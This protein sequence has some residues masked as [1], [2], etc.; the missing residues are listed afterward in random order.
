MDQP[1]IIVTGASRGLGAA[2]ARVSAR[3]GARVVLSARSADALKEEVAQITAAGGQAL[4]VPGDVSQ[5]ADCH[6]II[7]QA[8]E[9]FG[10]I[11][12]LVNN[13]GI[14]EPIAPL[15]E[16]DPQEWQRSW[17]VNVLGPVMLTRMALPQ[18]RLQQGRVINIS[19]GVATNVV[20]G[21]GAYSTAKAALN[22]FTAILAGEEPELTALA[23][24]PGLVDTA[25]Q[26]IIRQKGKGRMT[27]SN[28]NRLYGAYERGALLPPETPGRAIACLALYALH[29]WSG[30]ALQWDDEKVQTLLD[31]HLPE[32]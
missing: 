28:Y 22:H 32:I 17:A 8:L 6:A 12:A 4:A 25:M 2:I 14:V 26:A 3:A 15:A 31:E 16:A 11:H 5:E 1:T 19:S 9:H 27:Q 21:W 23:V 13:G 24:R 30:Q 7:R 10:Q 20:G 29:E 18:L